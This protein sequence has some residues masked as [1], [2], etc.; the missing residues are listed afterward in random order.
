MENR[1][2]KTGFRPVSRLVYELVF[3]PFF[4]MV[5]KKRWDE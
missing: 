2:N 4:L 5:V 1:L 3:K